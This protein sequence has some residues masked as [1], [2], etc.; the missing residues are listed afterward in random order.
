MRKTEEYE[1]ACGRAPEV[2]EEKEA[3]KNR[4][5]G[6]VDECMRKRKNSKIACREV[7]MSA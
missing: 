3:F 1:N 4:M 6:S 2:H 7:P 5:H